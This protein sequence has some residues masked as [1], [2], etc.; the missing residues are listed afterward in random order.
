[1]GV[2]VRRAC[3][4]ECGK[5]DRDA[6]GQ[7]RCRVEVMILGRD[8]LNAVQLAKQILNLVQLDGS[9]DLPPIR[10]KSG[11]TVG[12]GIFTRAKAQN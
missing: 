9:F 2:H 3:A 5:K 1:M 8:K 11:V 12:N 4:C 10:A 7:L 6:H